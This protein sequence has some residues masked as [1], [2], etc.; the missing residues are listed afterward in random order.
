MSRVDEFSGDSLIARITWTDGASATWGADFVT[1]PTDSAKQFAEVTGTANEEAIAEV[2]HT[3]GTLTVYRIRVGQKV[4]WDCTR[5][6]YTFP[7]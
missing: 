1:D 6:T 5:G 4:V 2:T 3:N 7:Q